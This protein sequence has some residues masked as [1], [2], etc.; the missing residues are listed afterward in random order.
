MRILTTDLTTV[1]CKLYHDCTF[2]H[3]FVYL[4]TNMYI[5]EY[6]TNIVFL[7]LATIS[8][9]DHSNIHTL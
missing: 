8:L 4:I 9:A 3:I 1:K 6:G 5:K 2:L 7:H